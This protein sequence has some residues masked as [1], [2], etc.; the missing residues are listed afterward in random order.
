MSTR[1]SATEFVRGFAD[2]LNRVSYRGETFVVVRGGR[3]VAEVRPAP[4]G[5]QLRDLPGMLAALPRLDAADAESYAADLEAAARE[6]N[7]LPPADPWA[8]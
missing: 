6:M 3:P 8:S 4:A 1:V 7:A 5:R 2:F